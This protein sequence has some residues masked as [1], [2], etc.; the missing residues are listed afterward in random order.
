MGSMRI[1]SLRGM[2][3]TDEQTR[4]WMAAARTPE[5]RACIRRWSKI[6]AVAVI[7]TLA[8]IALLILAPF[9]SVAV[10]VWT[11]VAD[12]DRPDLYWWIWGVTGVVAVGGVIVA[13]IAS[14]HRQQACYA[15]GRIAVGT[16]ERAIEHPG[17]GDDQTWFDLRIS[18]GLP[19]GTTLRRRLHL[20]GEGLDRR[21]GDRVRFRHNTLG[22]DDL[23][24]ILFDGWPDREKAGQWPGPP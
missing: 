23:D 13:M 22:P 6:E 16:V 17:S 7:T 3:A 9:A 1:I 5:T 4:E 21:I 24:D 11:S 2:V 18:A 12:I 10:A 20:D 14:G 15:D 8:G 19:G